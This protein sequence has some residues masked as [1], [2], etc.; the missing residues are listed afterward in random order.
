M[1]VITIVF[2]L[3]VVVSLTSLVMCLLSVAKQS[4]T[5]AEEMESQWIDVGC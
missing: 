3:S 2:G 5:M 4:D 1:F